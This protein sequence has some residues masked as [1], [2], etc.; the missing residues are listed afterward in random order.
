MSSGLTRETT[1]DG[2]ELA[3]PTYSV[4]AVERTLD[5]LDALA[6]EPEGLALSALAKHVSMPRSAQLP[7]QQVRTILELEGMPQLTS[8][9]LSDP[10]AY[11]EALQQVR[12]KGFATDVGER[13]EGACCVAVP[14]AWPSSNIKAAISLSSPAARFP[15]KNLVAVAA[16]LREAAE[17][18]SVALST[19]NAGSSRS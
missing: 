9:T 15:A 3:Q 14:L 13:E 2:A 18:I 5:I 12:A 17:E 10:D 11:V 8:K 16:Q 6:R 7:E 1:A 19:V 4:R